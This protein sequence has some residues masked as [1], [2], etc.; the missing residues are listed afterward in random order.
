[1][2]RRKERGTEKAARVAFIETEMLRVEPESCGQ[3]SM[4]LTAYAVQ[5]RVQFID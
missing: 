5:H 2:K 4:L 1:M 3:V